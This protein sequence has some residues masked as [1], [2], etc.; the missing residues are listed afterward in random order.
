MSDEPLAN[1]STEEF[2]QA[3]D[4]DS[5]GLGRDELARILLTVGAKY[6]YAL[7]PGAQATRSQISDFWH[8]LHLQEL[9]LAHACALGRN[10]AWEQFLSRYREPLTLAAIGITGS[11]AKGKELDD[12]LYSE[13]F[14]LTERDGQRQSPLA[15]Y[16]GRGSLKGF[17]RAT[18]AQRNADQ[19]RH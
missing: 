7:P 4:A 5:V 9:A 18:L 6:N 14:G 12:S 19:H 2:Y 10:A 1:V 11:A 17:L 15:Y 16:S 13:I 3:A 8:S